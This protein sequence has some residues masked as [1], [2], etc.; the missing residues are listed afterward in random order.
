[1]KEDRELEQYRSLMAAPKSWADGFSVRSVIG[2]IFIGLVMMP[3]SMYLGLLMGQGLSDAARWV[4]VVLFVELARRSYTTLSRPEIFVLFYMAGAVLASPFSSLLWTQYFVHS[5][6]A[7]AAGISDHI[8]AWLAPSQQV[9]DQR[10]FFNK[11][12]LGP[13]LMIVLGQFLG[14]LDRFGL[15]YVLFRVTSDVEKLPF[16]FAPVGALGITALAESSSTPTSAKTDSWRWRVF[17]IGSMIGLVF[18]ALY[19]GIPALSSIFLKKPVEL[20]PLIF[21]DYTSNNVPAATPVTLSFDLGNVLLG[22]VLPFYAVIGSLVGM[23][24]TWIA[25]PIMHH[26]HILHRWT[27]GMNAIDTSYAN[28]LDFYLS[29]GIGISLAIAAI[30]FYH[31]GASLR[32]TKRKP[33]GA[34]AALDAE[35]RSEES[36]W[37][38]LL[39]PPAG[40]GDIPL[41]AGIAIYFFSTTTYIVLC[42]FL[43]PDFPLWILLAYGFVYTPLIS[44]V[45]ARME[46]IAGQWVEIPMLREATFIAAG[47]MGYRGVGIWFAPIPINNYAG[48]VVDFRTQELTGTKFTSLIKAELIIFPVVIVSSL[49]FAQYFWRLAPIPS[50]QYPYTNKMFELNARQQA[51]VQ[52]STLG[53]GQGGEFYQAIQWKVIASGTGIGVVSY[54]AL[55][56]AGAP[57]MLIYGLIR[58]LGGGFIPGML[59]QLI[60]ALL[61]KFYFEKRF[62]LKWREYAPVLLAGFSCGIGLISMFS[63]GCLLIAKSVFQL[64]Y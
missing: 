42:R 20:L 13:I 29:F 38:R 40:R 27:P 50:A 28:S 36:A 19:V 35:T 21:A 14:R 6:A 39:H 57:T 17:S 56:F 32:K 58:G 53:G 34:V 41:W 63:L 54:A 52:S 12:W 30:G 1:M 48:T 15:G 43:V 59:P 5:Q 61:S 3:A 47:S 26:F 37:H 62:G 7:Q 33:E 11:A 22:M 55:A 64:P 24:I 46:G 2:C 16:P 45:A 8:P 60:G 51:L 23:I 9:I 18:G 49:L 31:V 44:Y 25:N 10:T 4:T